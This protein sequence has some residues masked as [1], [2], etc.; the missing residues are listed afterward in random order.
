MA[1]LGAS[2]VAVVDLIIIYPYILLYPHDLIII[3]SC[4]IKVVNLFL[5]FFSNKLC[6]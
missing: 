1:D 3:R 6:E 5:F 4:I 2:L